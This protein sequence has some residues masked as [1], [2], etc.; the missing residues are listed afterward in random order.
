L[1][2]NAEFTDLKE[3]RAIMRKK[4][5]KAFRGPG[6]LV[7]VDES[8]IGNSVWTAGRGLDWLKLRDFLAGLGTGRELIE[9]VVYA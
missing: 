7:L 5:T 8:N 1:V 9:M 2:Q 4:I 6:L 3:A